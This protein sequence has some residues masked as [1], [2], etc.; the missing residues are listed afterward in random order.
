MTLKGKVEGV[1]Q[2]RRT[3]GNPLTVSA[4]DRR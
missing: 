2:R 3:Y 1:S 4:P